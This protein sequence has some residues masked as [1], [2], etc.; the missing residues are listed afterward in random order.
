MTIAHR[1]SLLHEALFSFATFSFIA[2]LA[3]SVFRKRC[4]FLETILTCFPHRTHENPIG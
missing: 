4:D 3:H 1:F 2:S